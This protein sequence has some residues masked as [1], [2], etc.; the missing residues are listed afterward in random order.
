MGG[1]ASLGGWPTAYVLE[2]IG[3]ELRRQYMPLVAEPLPD[4]L[5]ELAAKLLGE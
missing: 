2:K 3:S 1:T 5:R 4:R